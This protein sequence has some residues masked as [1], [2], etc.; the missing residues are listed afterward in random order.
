MRHDMGAVDHRT[1][2]FLDQRELHQSD[3]ED[4]QPD[5]DPKSIARNL[6]WLCGPGPSAPRVAW[7]WEFVALKACHRQIK[8]AIADTKCF[9]PHAEPL[10]P[11]M[12]TVQRTAR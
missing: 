7:E 12:A 6:V 11:V 5:A 10:L 1:E 9:A 2:K 4:Q 3:R 8:F